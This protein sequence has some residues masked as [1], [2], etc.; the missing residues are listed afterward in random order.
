MSS[1]VV[2]HGTLRPDGTL[3]LREKLDL[4]AGPVRVTV[5]TVGQPV[6]PERFWSMMQAIWSNLRTSGRNP[7]TREQIDAEIDALRKEAEDELSGIEKLHQAC[8]EAREQTGQSP[9]HST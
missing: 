9:E 4:P 2:V 8:R 3:E 1:P 5:E 7:R 6:Q